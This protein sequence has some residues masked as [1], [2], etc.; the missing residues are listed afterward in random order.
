MS[1]LVFILNCIKLFIF[2]LFG[3]F[4]IGF[5]NGYLKETSN[6]ND[7]GRIST[8]YTGTD[9]YSTELDRDD[10]RTVQQKPSSVD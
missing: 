1:F 5:V 8:P 10:Y 7:R 2:L 4:A 3:V 6:A 9:K